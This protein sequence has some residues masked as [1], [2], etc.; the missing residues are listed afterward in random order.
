MREADVPDDENFFRCNSK[1]IGT[2]FNYIGIFF[3]NNGRQ[4]LG[5]AFDWNHFRGKEE[6]NASFVVLKG[7]V[8]AICALL[9]ASR[10]VP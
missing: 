1:N 5:L 4:F 10:P 7:G 9:R 2:F 6:G 8:E 3:C